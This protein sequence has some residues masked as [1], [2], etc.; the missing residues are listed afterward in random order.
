[1]RFHEIS[2]SKSRVNMFETLATGP[3][4]ELAQECSSFNEFLK[5]TD[6]MDV[7][8]RGHFGDTVGNNAFMTDYVGHAWEYAGGEDD[9]GQV[10][11]FA[12]DWT[13]VIFFKDQQFN[14]MRSAYGHYS[15]RQLAIIYK[16]AFAEDR[17]ANAMMNGEMNGRQAIEKIIEI[18]QGDHRYSSISDNPVINDLF[19]PLMQRFAA[20]R[21]KNII[22]FVG[23]DYGGQ[24]EFVVHDVSKLVNLRDLYDRVH[25]ESRKLS[26]AIVNRP[27][28]L[29]TFVKRRIADLSALVNEFEQIKAIVVSHEDSERMLR[30]FLRYGSDYDDAANDVYYLMDIANRFDRYLPLANLREALDNYV[31]Y[32][33]TFLRYVMSTF[34]SVDQI[35]ASA[36]VVFSILGAADKGAQDYGYKPGDDDPEYRDAMDLRDALVRLSVALRRGYALVATI[37]SKLGEVA[38]IGAAGE[39]YRPKHAEVEPL[40]HA[41]AFATEILRDGF[42]AEPPVNRRGLGNY[43]KQQTISFTHSLKIA[44][45]LMRALKDVW[46]I[47]HG[48]VTAKQIIS[49]MKHEGI[50]LAK[51]ES[52]LG[53]SVETGDDPLFGKRH[54]LK[55]LSEV[56]GPEE[57]AKLYRI[58]LAYSKLRTDPFFTYIEETLAMMKNRDIKDIAILSCEVRLKPEDEYLWGESEFRLPADRVISVKKVM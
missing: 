55:R 20:E 54:R 8:Y 1:M 24:N 42:E 12:V 5:K 16:N 52:S 40:Y 11:A 23:G 57:T 34:E 30:D 10:D 35:D 36:L 6:G 28:H 31:K 13:D 26:E 44:Q 14:E 2:H 32:G 43:G 3:F 50:D 4:I 58:Y 53:L 18:L 33:S 7:L 17:L 48:Q 21:G 38:N 39:K 37:Q 27:H 46:M 45:D 15:Y 41:T 51:A 49:W 56:T 22:G 9:G 29:G 19:I 25:S 47:A